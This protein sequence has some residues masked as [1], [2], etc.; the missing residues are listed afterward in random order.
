MHGLRALTL[1]TALSVIIL[2]DRPIDVC[3][4]VDDL[5]G[6]DLGC[7]GRAL[8]ETPNIDRLCA[9]GMKFTQAYYQNRVGQFQEQPPIAQHLR[10]RLQA[11]R[12]K[13]GCRAAAVQSG[14]PVRTWTVA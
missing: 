5:G 10:H 6:A 3:F 13:T 12:Q 4:L 14:V 2:G 8:H 7:F 9:S 1:C 11:W